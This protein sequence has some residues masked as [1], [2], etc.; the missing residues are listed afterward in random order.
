VALV[1]SLHGPARWSASTSTARLLA[2]AARRLADEAVPALLA[3]ADA[4]SLP[5][6]RPLV[7]RR[8]RLRHLLAYRPSRA[9]ALAEIRPRALSRR[10][11]HPRDPC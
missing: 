7:R 4:R 5:F 8:G 1:A 9:D 11:V 10:P 6:S 2:A 3:R